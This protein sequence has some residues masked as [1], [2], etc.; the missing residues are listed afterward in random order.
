MIDSLINLHLKSEPGKRS[1]FFEVCPFVFFVLFVVRSAAVFGFKS[2]VAFDK[3]SRAKAK[4]SLRKT[5][6]LSNSV[7][8]TWSTTWGLALPRV[9][10]ITW[11]L[12]KLMAF[13]FPAL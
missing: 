9:A 7:R 1:L 5:Y 12:R 4:D 3:L 11:P 13:S 8:S 6:S 2:S 10:F